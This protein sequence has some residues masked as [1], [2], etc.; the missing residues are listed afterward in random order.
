MFTLGIFNL[1]AERPVGVVVGYANTLTVH[2]K[3]NLQPHRGHFLYSDCASLFLT[4][5]K[6]CTIISV[7]Y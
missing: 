4:R 5:Q 3:G 6:S 7:I 1:L 2:L